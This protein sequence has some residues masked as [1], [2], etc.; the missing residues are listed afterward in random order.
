MYPANFDRT[1]LFHRWVQICWQD[2]CGFFIR[3]SQGNSNSSLTR[4]E[5]WKYI[6]LPEYTRADCGSIIIYPEVDIKV[7][8]S[9]VDYGDSHNISLPPMIYPPFLRLST[10][11][12]QIYSLSTIIWRSQNLLLLPRIHSPFPLV[13]FSNAPDIPALP[14]YTTPFHNYMRRV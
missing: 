3:N 7:H 13:T 12:L 11:P 5:V 10:L 1:S 4:C 8:S 14:E 2:W 6:A 9:G